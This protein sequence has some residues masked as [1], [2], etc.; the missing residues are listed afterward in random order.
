MPRKIGNELKNQ[1][2]QKQGLRPSTATLLE[3]PR[4]L[5]NQLPQK[6]GLRQ[7]QTQE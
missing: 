6:Q 3:S 4:T 2:P 5:K 7:S 1:L